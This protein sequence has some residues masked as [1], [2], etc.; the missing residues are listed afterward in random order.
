MS[1][2]AGRPALVWIA[3]AL[4]IAANA[5]IERNVHVVGGGTLL[6][7][8]NPSAAFVSWGVLSAPP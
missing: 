5:V 7:I 1:L 4:G 6:A 3:G 8:D 2:A